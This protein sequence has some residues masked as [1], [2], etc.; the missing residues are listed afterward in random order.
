[1]KKIILLLIMIYTSNTHTITSGKEIKTKFSD[2]V[3]H[4]IPGI[5]LIKVGVEVG[6]KIKKVGLKKYFVDEVIE[7]IIVH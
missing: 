5:A 3:A 2:W 6:V 4:T 1:M 7:K